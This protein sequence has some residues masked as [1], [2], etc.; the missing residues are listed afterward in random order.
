MDIRYEASDNYFRGFRRI[1][2]PG[3]F[4]TI[5]RGGHL[6]ILRGP[7]SPLYGSGSAR[8]IKLFTKTAKRKR[9]TISEPMAD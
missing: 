6:E 2:N 9:F 7:V 4:N 3:A 5:V 1:N 8:A